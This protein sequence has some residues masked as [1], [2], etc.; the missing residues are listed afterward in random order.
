MS[1][2]I[3]VQIFPREDLAVIPAAMDFLLGLEDGKNP[4]IKAVSKLAKAFALISSVD[5]AIAIPDEVGFFRAIKLA[6]IKHT[7]RNNR[8]AEDLDIVGE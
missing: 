2:F 8:S 7:T 6:F 5:K 3:G 1:S 4:Y